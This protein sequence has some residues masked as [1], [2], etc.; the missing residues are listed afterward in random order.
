MALEPQGVDGSAQGGEVTCGEEE[1]EEM[2]EDGGEE[3]EE[4]W[5]TYRK[6]MT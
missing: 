2:K 3:M 5:D 6:K 1:E 4:K